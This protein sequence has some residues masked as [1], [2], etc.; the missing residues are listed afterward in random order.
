MRGQK[1][2][3][4]SNWTA[5][6]QEVAVGRT[7]VSIP[8]RRCLTTQEAKLCEAEPSAPSQPNQVVVEPSDKKSPSKT[9]GETVT[10]PNEATEHGNPIA[11]EVIGKKRQVW[12]DMGTTLKHQPQSR[13]GN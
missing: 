5:R 6:S 4:C 8:V 2:A 10:K 12:A 9:G 1:N 7:N 13:K 11:W 3:T